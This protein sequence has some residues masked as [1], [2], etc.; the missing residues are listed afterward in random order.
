MDCKNVVSPNFC[1][2]LNFGPKIVDKFPKGISTSIIRDYHPANIHPLNTC[3]HEMG[4]VINLDKS[5]RINMSTY[6]NTDTH[7]G[8]SNL[9]GGII[10]YDIIVQAI[11]KAETNGVATLEYC[12]KTPVDEV[13]KNYAKKPYYQFTDEDFKTVSSFFQVV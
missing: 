3:K 5:P 10:P 4:A 9:L 7:D 6:H 1:G 8:S 2:M 11:K 13:I 12:G